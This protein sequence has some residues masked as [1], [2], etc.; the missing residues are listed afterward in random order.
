VTVDAPPGL[1]DR[2]LGE[3][4]LQLERPLYNVVYRWLWD[5]EEAR[6]VVQE[7]FVRLWRHRRRIDLVTVRGLVYRTALNLAAN[8][9]KWRRLR[10]MIGLSS[11]APPGSLPDA[12]IAAERQQ[13]VRRAVEALPERLRRVIVLCELGE[14]SY[15]EVAAVLAIP[16]GTVASRRN[17]AIR[18]LRLA[19]DEGEEKS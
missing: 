17:A 13:R 11:P 16:S 3:L 18:Q 8:R 1:D 9:R 7:A 14:M 15:A 6:D 2:T 19:L 10:R 5:A 12:L 4:Y